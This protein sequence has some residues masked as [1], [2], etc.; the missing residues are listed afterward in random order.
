MIVKVVNKL[1]IAAV[2]PKDD[3]PIARN[4]DRPVPGQITLQWVQVAARTAHVAGN[5]SHIQGRQQAQEPANVVGTHARYVAIQIQRSQP[6]VA[7]GA[8]HSGFSVRLNL[9]LRK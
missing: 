9:T 3:P 5:L 4:T 2:E 6:L 1:H 7:K 8:D